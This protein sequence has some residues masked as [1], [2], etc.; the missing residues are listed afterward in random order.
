MGGGL[1]LHRWPPTSDPTLRAWDAADDLLTDHL[2][3]R[4]E[5]GADFPA[6]ELPAGDVP[7]LL[8]N[9]TFGAL[10]VRLRALE[11]ARPIL[12]VVETA[13]A[14]EALR[15]NLV[16]NDLDADSVEVRP[17]SELP[18]LADVHSSASALVLL[19]IPK[20]LARLE[21]QLRELRRL[22]EP[23]GVLLAGA[24][25]RHVHTSTLS[26]FET[27]VGP[28]RSSL[29]RRKARLIHATLD[30]GLEPSVEPGPARWSVEGVEVVGHPGVFSAD[31]LDGGTRLLLEALGTEGWAE[32]PVRVAVDL[33]C[34]SGVLGAVVARRGSPPIHLHLRD[35]D[36]LAVA[37]A[38]ATFDSVAAR[39]RSADAKATDAASD[40]E[41]ESVDLV[42]CN[43]PFH[44]QGAR[45]GDTA[46]R[47]VAD[48]F[49]ILRP[50]GALWIVGNRHLR[51]PLDL[52]RRFGDAE[53]VASDRRFVV[54]RAIRRPVRGR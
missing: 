22:V 30:A 6:V 27:L 26:L 4:T 16:T 44:A 21:F 28:T 54:V 25:T 19:K 23:G 7:V 36:H 3:G 17:L 12:S 46:Q 51:Y 15:R 9:D 5:I 29:A 53:V 24:M 48:A 10:A 32:R 2:A 52:K 42:V 50:G 35:A 38:R 18:H 31:R 1:T 47:M 49:R 20:A 41:P 33:G 40:L 43:P 37:S 34:G 11:P 39:D 45:G 13:L 14:E 8:L